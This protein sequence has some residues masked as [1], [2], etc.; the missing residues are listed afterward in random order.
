MSLGGVHER[1]G[2]A[3]GTLH[4]F[5]ALVGLTALDELH[6]RGQAHGSEL[7]WKALCAV[8]DLFVGLSSLRTW[9]ECWGAANRGL[10]NSN[11]RT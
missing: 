4:V 6:L 9:L 7:M 10:H 1:S 3:E 11:C 2:T 5:H 8:Q